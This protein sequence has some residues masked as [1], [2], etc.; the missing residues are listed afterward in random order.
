MPNPW[1]QLSLAPL[2]VNAFLS[3]SPQRHGHTL[4]PRGPDGPGRSPRPRGPR[5]PCILLCP[6]FGLHCGP[7]Q[8]HGPSARCGGPTDALVPARSPPPRP[9]LLGSP[10]HIYP[11][12]PLGASCRPP[13]LEHGEGCCCAG[14]L[15][16][17][18]PFL[19]YPRPSHLSTG[20]TGRAG[21]ACDP[22]PGCRMDTREWALEDTPSPLMSR[23]DHWC[24]VAKRSTPRYM[25]DIT[26]GPAAAMP[27]T[28]RRPGSAWW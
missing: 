28:K 16:G 13:F 15:L 18:A 26:H 22:A 7:L 23:E 6:P 10:V 25:G 4:H 8:R 27:T 1:W 17:P 21:N 12:G 9:L 20:E 24:N 11:A 3:G 5:G 14:S 2:A 19:S